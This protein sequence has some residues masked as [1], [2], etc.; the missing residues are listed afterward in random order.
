MNP[1]FYVR[2]SARLVALILL[3]SALLAGLA[4]AEEPRTLVGRVV[5][6]ATGDQLRLLLPDGRVVE[7]QLAGVEAPRQGQY[8]FEQSRAWLASQLVRQIVSA[9]CEQIADGRYSCLVFPDDREINLV[10]LYHGLAKNRE[11]MSLM[12]RGDVYQAA[13]RQAKN[14]GSGLWGK[15]SGD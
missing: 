2:I 11:S 13:Q 5:E 8:F 1:S 3:Q 4:S 14:S 9:D 7:I 15:A 10:S 12:V 6:V